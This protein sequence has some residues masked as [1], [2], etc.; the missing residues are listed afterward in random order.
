VTD[1]ELFGPEVCAQLDAF[2]DSA[3]PLNDAQVALL[4]PLFAPELEPGRA[5]A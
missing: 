2:A 5:A 1:E 3:P 4:A